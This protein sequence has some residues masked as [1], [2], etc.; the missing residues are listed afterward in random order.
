MRMSDWSSDV[1]SSDL[2]CEKKRPSATDVSRLTT[3]A[4]G[5]ESTHSILRADG[6]VGGRSALGGLPSHLSASA[7]ARLMEVRSAIQ[8]H[9]RSARGSGGKGCV[10]TCRSRWAPDHYKKKTNR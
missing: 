1:C 5:A 6:V 3:P 9:V 8:R 10:R 4:G 7:T 2:V